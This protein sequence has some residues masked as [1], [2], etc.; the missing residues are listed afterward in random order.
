LGALALAG[1]AA[2]VYGI[3]GA[4]DMQ[5]E[6]TSTAIALRMNPNSPIL[7]R[8]A[9]NVSGMTAQDAST[10][11]R[12]MAMAATSG[13]NNPKSFQQAFTRIAKAADVLWMSP[14][15]ID[16]VEAVKEMSTL[17]HL[18]GQYQGPKFQHMLDRATEMMYVQPEAL[19]QLVMQ[20]RLFVGAGLSR[21]VSEEDLFKQAMIM[22]QT[23]NLRSRGGSGLARVIEYLSGAATV[24]GHLSRVQHNA[25]QT[26]GLTGANGAL[27]PQYLNHG[28]LLLQKA[29]D[30][31]EHIRGQ[32]TPTAFGNLITN[33]FLAQGGRYL[34]TT[35]QPNVYKKAQENWTVM[36]ELHG[37]DSLWHKYTN[38]FLYQFNIFTTNFANLFKAVFM[39]MLPQLTTLFMDMGKA[40]S[41]AVSWLSAHP[42]SAKRIGEIIVALTG[43]AG[44]RV[45]AGTLVGM[46]RFSGILTG[47][48]RDVPMITRFGSLI[49][50]VFFLGIGKKALGA[51]TSFGFVLKGIPTELKGAATGL[52]L[53]QGAL[54]GLAGV[55]GAGTALGSVI[56]LLYGA[57]VN[58]KRF[59]NQKSDRATDLNHGITNPNDFPTQVDIFGRV[60]PKPKP[61]PKP[62][63]STQFLRNTVHSH[64]QK[65]SEIVHRHTTER[66]HRIDRAAK[67]VH[68][69]Q[70]HVHIAKV[71]ITL[72]KGTPKQHADMLLQHFLGLGTGQRTAAHLPKPL[73][74][75]F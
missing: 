23:G 35:L 29:V 58:A 26:L 28:K 48:G 33:A 73:T 9:F 41:K 51:L 6:L 37:V 65:M 25:M 34:N 70:Q 45:A 20:G 22:G 4:A 67:N 63:F 42:D 18:F 15:H 57:H 19:K 38:N 2:I 14:K 13:L 17:S 36:N 59:P 49:D 64:V 47:I 3:K 53:L 11:S 74:V 39:P 71:E 69:T 55:L 16:P 40:L 24:T 56:G 27:L 1:G 60:I 61:A 10:I 54:A 72:P 44:I 7:P 31:L 62:F 46:A 21:G 52:E 32:F 43:I 75:G 12:E 30:H 50:S 5:R 8:M 68:L 66:E